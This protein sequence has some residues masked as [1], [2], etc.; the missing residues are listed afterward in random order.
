[1][2]LIKV[3]ASARVLDML[4]LL[5]LIA[6]GN[7]GKALNGQVCLSVELLP[8]YVGREASLASYLHSLVCHVLYHLFTDQTS[9]I[10]PL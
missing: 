5:G 9:L 4:K 7:E 6:G 8:S 2:I 10:G 3:L 1:M